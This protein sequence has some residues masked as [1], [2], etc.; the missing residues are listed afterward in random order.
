MS[1]RDPI[2][3]VTAALFITVPMSAFSSPLEVS[4][5]FTTLGEAQVYSEET[6]FVNESEAS[7]NFS[8]STGTS[9]GSFEMILA[10]EGQFGTY[11][12]MRY[13]D[14]SYAGPGSS[15]FFNDNDALL[16]G[17]PVYDGLSI[18]GLNIAP[19]DTLSFEVGIFGGAFPEGLSAYSI[20]GQP[21]SDNGERD[22]NEVP[23][24]ATLLLFGGGLIGLAAL[25]RR[26]ESRA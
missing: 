4:F 8:N 7:F 1:F 12:F 22:P 5:D 21:F 23:L 11:D 3:L 25:T 2:R 14:D 24:P 17:E 15:S 9:W 26:R 16:D 20:S 6:S 19:G 10:G 18:A 13:Q